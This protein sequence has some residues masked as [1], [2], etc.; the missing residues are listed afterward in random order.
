MLMVGV[1]LLLFLFKSSSNLASAYG[2]AVTG[3]MFVDTL[4]F[5]YIVRY[6][7]KKPLWQAI[8]AVAVFGAIDL[9]F[10]TSNLLKFFD[11]AVIKS[12][13]RSL[14]PMQTLA[15]QFSGTEMIWISFPSLLK[16]VT[17]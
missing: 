4:L 16:T 2:I 10:M 3:S 1:L 8:A 7:W 15:V 5:F 6:M 11:G 14:P 17:P 12:V 9:V 13:L